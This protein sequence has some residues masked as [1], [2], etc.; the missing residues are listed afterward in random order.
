M[1]FGNKILGNDHTHDKRKV[2]VKLED[3]NEIF[4]ET[5]VDGLVKMFEEKL[6]LN[7]EKQSRNFSPRGWGRCVRVLIRGDKGIFTWGEKGR[8]EGLYLF[9]M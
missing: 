4:P 8:L 7:D 5:R 1:E 2:D 9:P 3:E 6:I